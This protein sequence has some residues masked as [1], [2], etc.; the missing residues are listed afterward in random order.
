MILNN[1]ILEAC[2]TRDLKKVGKTWDQKIFKKF[3]QVISGERKRKMNV[4][5]KFDKSS[6]CFEYLTLM[7]NMI[8]VV[9]FS[10][11]GWFDPSV[12]QICPGG[13]AK[14]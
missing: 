13:W 7:K 10:D 1:F 11:W 2:A 12:E 4:V 6:F 9:N 5:I 3:K 8:F 14:D